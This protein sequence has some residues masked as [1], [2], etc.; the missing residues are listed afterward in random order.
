MPVGAPLDYLATDIL[1]PF[2]E[3]TQGNRYALAVIDYFTKRVEIFAIPD[4]SAATC[5]EIIQDEVIGCYGYPYNIHS[6]QGCNYE[7]AIYAELCHL[8]EVKKTQASH[9]H[10]FCNG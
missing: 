4:Q 3:S 10:P 1:G 6:D 5:P 8:Q 2:P 9:K 7:N